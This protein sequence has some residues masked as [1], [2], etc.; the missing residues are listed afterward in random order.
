V[1]I[2]VRLALIVAA[3]AAFAACGWKAHPP[4]RSFAFEGRVISVNLERHTALIHHQDVPGLMDAM[5][6]DFLIKDDAT[7]RRLQPKDHLKGRLLDD[8]NRPWIEVV[9]ISKPQPGSAAAQRDEAAGGRAE[10][11]PRPSDSDKCT[12]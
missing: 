6:M 10:T 2:A 9:T 8:G 1:R 12:K 11:C 4:V 3:L 5:T 7:L